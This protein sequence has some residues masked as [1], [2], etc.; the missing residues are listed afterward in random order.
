[1]TGQRVVEAM[2]LVSRLPLLRFTTVPE[3][4]KRH[5]EWWVGVLK[6]DDDKDHISL[7][8]IRCYP[9]SS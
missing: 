6:G 9:A 4:C 2:V 7:T 8:I 1:M 5:G 3:Q